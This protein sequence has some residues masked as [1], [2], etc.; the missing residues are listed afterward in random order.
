MS[1]WLSEPLLDLFL[2]VVAIPNTLTDLIILPS[3]TFRRRCHLHHFSR[4]RTKDH[5]RQTKETRRTVTLHRHHEIHL[6]TIPYLHQISNYQVLENFIFPLILNNQNLNH[7]LPIYKHP[8]PII[9]KFRNQNQDDLQLRKFRITTQ[10]D[11]QSIKILLR[12]I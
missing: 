8:Q 4:T 7:H 9:Y 10:D 3:K 6:T 12:R 2:F 1:L 5:H 11:L